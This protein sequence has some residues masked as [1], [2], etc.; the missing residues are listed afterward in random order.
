MKSLL[1][2]AVLLTSSLAFAVPT[3][4]PQQKDF[5]VLTIAKG[6]TGLVNKLM[7]IL[8][9]KDTHAAPN[10]TLDEGD[11]VSIEDITVHFNDE[12]YPFR[13][14]LPFNDLYVDLYSLQPHL[15]PIIHIRDLRD[16]C[17]ALAF[18]HKKKIDKLIGTDSTFD[19][20]LL[21]VIQNSHVLGSHDCKRN[22]EYA[23][24]WLDLPGVVVTRFEEL[25]GDQGGGSDVVQRQVIEELA[26]ILNI[27]LTKPIWDR[28]HSELFGGNQTFRKGQINE[29]KER[30]KEEHKE[31]FK[32]VMGDTLI[33][34]GYEQDN[35]W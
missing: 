28:I 1:L 18:A 8:S 30:F 29:W 31:A 19:E 22:G 24:D 13:H 26:T 34:L 4:Q 27:T 21:F 25:V 11:D 12:V 3:E 2:F 23:A 32:A 14:F 10:K 20:R 15:I 16:V 5:F 9:G 7:R 17:I 33:R 6:G 35:N